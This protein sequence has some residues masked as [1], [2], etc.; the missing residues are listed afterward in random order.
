MK[1]SFTIFILA[2]VAGG[3]YMLFNFQNT[4][5][6]GD[7]ACGLEGIW[8]IIIDLPIIILTA[9]TTLGIYTYKLAKKIPVTPFEKIAVGITIIIPIIWVVYFMAVLGIGI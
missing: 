6:V 4:C 2:L 7:A 8:L 5:A 9:L 3:F 1:I